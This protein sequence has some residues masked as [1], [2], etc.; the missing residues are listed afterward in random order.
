VKTYPQARIVSLG[1]EAAMSS[2]E[3]T[4]GSKEVNFS[5]VWPERF[6]EVQLRVT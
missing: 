6:F 4:N 2:G 5:K 3:G 1:S